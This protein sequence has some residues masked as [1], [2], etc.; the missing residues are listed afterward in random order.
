MIIKKSLPK[1]IVKNP[2]SDKAIIKEQF[3]V[4]KFIK[5]SFFVLFSLVLAFFIYSSVI[6]VKVVFEESDNLKNVLASNISKNESKDSNMILTAFIEIIQREGKVSNEMATNYAKWI[7]ESS[8][9]QKLDP[10]LVLSIMSVESSFNYQ[11]IS[12]SNAIGLMQV[13]YHWHKEKV[14][15]TA[16]LYDPKINIK[17]GAKI[18]REYIDRSDNEVESMLRYNGSLGQSPIYSM[19]VMETKQ[20]FNFE[21]LRKLANKTT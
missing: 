17:T 21:I 2:F 7:F 9:E 18:V 13:I 3:N 20:R 10:V 19:K 8:Y 5:L 12:K 6:Y 11:A 1:L 14:N 16:D 4:L 15:T